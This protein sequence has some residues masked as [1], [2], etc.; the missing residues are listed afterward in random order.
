[1]RFDLRTGRS[2][3]LAEGAFYDLEVSPDGRFVALA[4]FGETVPVDPTVPFLQ[5]QYPQR[6]LLTLVDLQTGQD[7]SPDP[8]GDL[9]PGLLAWSPQGERL[10]VWMRRKGENWA[11]GRFE[12][13]DPLVRRRDSLD[14]GGWRPTIIQS[15]LRT[16]MAA[17]DWLGE[18]PVV[19]AHEREGRSDWIRI[20]VA[21]PRPM[22]ADME[23]PSSSLAAIDQ[24]HMVVKSGRDL[25]RVGPE[26]D[27]SRLGQAMPQAWSAFGYL[28]SQGQRFQYNHAPRRDWVLM[29]R[30]G[31]WSRV[32]IGTGE[33]F[34][35][36]VQPEGRVAAISEEITV[37]LTT[38]NR[39]RA[40]FDLGPG[41]V[42]T[43]TNAHLGEVEFAVRHEVRHRAP[44]GSPTSSWLYMPSTPGSRPPPL[45]V[46]PYPGVAL[47]GPNS[48]AEPGS[49]NASYNVQ[50]MT[51]AGFAVLVPSLP[52]SHSPHDPSADLAAEIL[53]IVEAAWDVAPFDPQRLVLWGHSFGGHAVLSAAVQSPRFS[54][55]VALN[56]GYELISAWG[57]FAPNASVLPERGLS[58]RS[59]AGWVE[60][61]QGGMG[62]PPWEAVDRYIRNSPA[63]SAD[64]IHAPVLLIHG[65]RDF[66]NPGQAEAV[67]SALYRQN[68]DAVLITYRGE[69][70]ILASPANIA[71]MYGF[72][73]DWLKTVLDRPGPMTPMIAPNSPPGPGS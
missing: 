27:S 59:R 31:L 3:T 52:R 25:W 10:L 12:V 48:S 8:E 22:T 13:I 38:D 9:A 54:A 45:I 24:G 50:L 55:V 53:A 69:G 14:L 30:D 57:E 37:R 70:H 40:A 68:K 66:I 28:V 67:F 36:A 73:F 35:E 56:G 17:A 4:A 21:G 49:E 60:T 58:I 64:R 5:G 26:G 11:D 34:G 42:L 61:G 51:A 20:T 7:W 6:R 23:A 1:M 46:I 44:D 72:A 16:P 62:A 71:D 39:A 43:R 47:Q 32:R 2:R 33:T 15:P 63:L 29:E 18:T 41:K 19:W 65:D